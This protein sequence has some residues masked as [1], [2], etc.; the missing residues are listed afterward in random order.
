M[1]YVVYLIDA[2]KFLTIP[3]HWL[4]NGLGVILEKFVD[5][6]VNSNQKHLCY[7]SKYYDAVEKFGI[8]VSTEFPCRGDEACYNCFVLKFKGK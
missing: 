3:A 4:R 6:G 7:W 8:G 2:K 5:K 1:F